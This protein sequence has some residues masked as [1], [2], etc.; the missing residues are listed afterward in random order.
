MIALTAIIKDEAKVAERW[1]RSVEGECAAWVIIDTGST[2]DTKEVVERE[3]VRQ[4]VSNRFKHHD[5]V[6]FGTNRTISLREAEKPFGVYEHVAKWM[7][8]LDAD[9][10]LLG[11]ISYLDD[12]MDAYE[13]EVRQGNTA[14]WSVRL[15]RTG[16]G[17]EYVGAAHAV[18][19]RKGTT[20]VG[21]IE[22]AT[23]HHH[24][25][26]GCKEG[27]RERNRELLEKAVAENP[28]DPRSW[29]YLAQECRDA[30]D[31]EAACEAYRRRIEL[32]GWDEERW[33]AMFQRGVLLEDNDEG[34]VQLQEA[35]RF[36]PARLEA[37][38]ALMLRYR[39]DQ[40]YE[41]AAAVG[42]VAMAFN[43]GP[44]SDR[45]FVNAWMYE[46]GIQN[47]F[48]KACI[49]LRN[50]MT[51]EDVIPMLIAEDGG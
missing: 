47:E 37:L 20:K 42:A 46:Q 38:Y 9:E 4:R 25:D 29:F 35:F 28:D 40:N 22:S 34:I 43:G 27:R 1:L 2:D 44:P 30:G 14:W 50:Q 3:A 8:I 45:L 6:D 5:W 21:K 7:L 36:R 24:N 33:N 26:G 15:L 39:A 11:S 10:E 13:I 19:E 18:P 51:D 23:I 49:L 16:R 31:K 12:E 17:W 48:G 41:A 32:V